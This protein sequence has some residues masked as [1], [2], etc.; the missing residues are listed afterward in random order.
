ML[1]LTL[2]PPGPSKVGLGRSRAG[3]RRAGACQARQVAVL[4]ARKRQSVRVSAFKEQAKPGS[5][6]GAGPRSAGAQNTPPPAPS[7]PPPPPPP[8]AASAPPPPAAAAEAGAP[9]AKSPRPYSKLT[10]G[11]RLA[12]A[13]GPG[14]VHYKRG[15]C[16]WVRV[17]GAG[18]GWGVG[19]SSRCPLLQRPASSSPLHCCT[20]PALWRVSGTWV[21]CAW[22]AH[23][24]HSPAP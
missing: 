2:H 12:G 3:P 20:H 15:T 18:G 8:P 19:S 4:T 17:L 11:R 7:A 9:V 21:A 16:V 10:L 1:P 24:F 5:N 14:G 13:H 6:P 23:L 22:Q